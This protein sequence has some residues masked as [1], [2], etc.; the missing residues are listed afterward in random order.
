M[1]F[2]QP[3]AGAPE[4]TEST[5][6]WDLVKLLEICR[7]VETYCAQIY[8]LYEKGYADDQELSRL[9]AKT[10]AE[11]ENHASQFVLAIKMRRENFISAV[12]MDQVKATQILNMVKG[13]YRNLLAHLPSKIDALRSAIK[14]EEHLAQFHLASIASFEDEG[15]RKMFHAMMLADNEHKKAI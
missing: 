14:L 10:Y 11:E 3:H 5:L 2:V 8:Q 1:G 7:D 15:I 13:I 12:N 4:R 9:W 6:N